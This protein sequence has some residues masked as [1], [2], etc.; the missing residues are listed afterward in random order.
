MRAIGG[1]DFFQWGGQVVALHSKIERDGVAA[2]AASGSASFSCAAMPAN[3]L[4]SSGRVLLGFVGLNLSR[5][6]N[7]SGIWRESTTPHGMY[8][9]LD[10]LRATE[11]HIAFHLLPPGFCYGVGQIHHQ[12]T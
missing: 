10:R 2:L 4:R 1:G 12:R 11:V 8:E 9:V 7:I 5:V 3:D 6:T